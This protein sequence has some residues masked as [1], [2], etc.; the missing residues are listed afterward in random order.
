MFKKSMSIVLCVIMLMTIFP[1]GAM[2]GDVQQNLPI[3]DGMETIE[4]VNAIKSTVTSGTVALT[5]DKISGSYA[6]KVT[7]TDEPG[8]T[9]V[10]YTLAES[11]QFEVYNYSQIKLWVKPGAGAKWIKFYTN[12]TVLI[13]NDKNAD[14]T[15]KVGEDLVSGKWN[16]VI[17]DLN[18]TSDPALTQAANLS[19]QTNE[20]ST[21]TYDEITSIYAPGSSV[22]IAQMV[23]AQT[24]M[25]NGELRFKS[26]G[27]G[28]YNTTPTV[29]VSSSAP[30]PTFS[31]ASTAYK[32]DG[33]QLGS[34]T[35]RYETGKFGQGVMMEEGTTNL[36][37]ANQSSIETS[38]PA[39]YVAAGGT[40]TRDTTTAWQGSAC[41]KIVTT[42]GLLDGVD[43][44]N[45][46]VN[47]GF[48]VTAGQTY[49]ASAYV[50]GN[51]GGEVI[52]MYIYASDWTNI[53]STAVTL[54]NTAWQRISVTVTIPTGKT[55]IFILIRKSSDAGIRTWFIDGLQLEQKAYATSWQIG[56]TARSA[57]T[58]TIP[59]AGNFTKGNW[60]VELTYISK[61]N[62]T[63]SKFGLIW[64]Y[65][66]D[67]GNY[68]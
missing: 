58:L 43:L 16:E 34:G 5:Q 22:G 36:L 52:T 63:A 28:G 60:C 32:K 33:T 48:P 39:G 62:D 18:R 55:G 12:S 9:Y 37:T 8:K 29:L 4:R 49:T 44:W 26:N 11:V 46:A 2:A 23:N 17:L 41:M 19:V 6:I 68:V 14:G 67:A 57:E 31:R 40:L 1:L 27:T 54:T 25:F 66:I 3:D 53:G 20:F 21:W 38:L 45:G 15:F 35:P 51:A 64:C 13:K 50:K 7:A 65:T 47:T 61:V 42:T 59:T 10:S 24:E 30:Q 56:G